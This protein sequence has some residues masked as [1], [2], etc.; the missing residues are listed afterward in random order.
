MA[1]LRDTD[2]L[3]LGGGSAAGTVQQ[4][5]HNPSA[6]LGPRGKSQAF[7]PRAIPEGSAEKSKVSMFATG[8]MAWPD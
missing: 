7:S 6:S 3:D 4:R 2:A 5:G 8:L 1:M